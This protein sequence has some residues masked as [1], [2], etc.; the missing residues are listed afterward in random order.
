M[1]KEHIYGF[2]VGL[3]VFL[4]FGAYQ[5]PTPVSN[6]EHQELFAFLD[7][8]TELILA[9]EKQPTFHSEQIAALKEAAIV[10][11]ILILG[12]DENTPTEV[13]LRAASSNNAAPNKG[14][15]GNSMPFQNSTAVPVTARR[16]NTE[17][18]ILAERKLPE[19]KQ[20]AK[21][22]IVC[23]KKIDTKH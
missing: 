23:E 8:V 19:K 17:E 4:V 18:L 5:Q 16:K 15:P 1:K 21:S 14:K 22:E 9:L 10:I 13:Y 12:P 3:I 2:V 6:T 20:R 11:T 7:E